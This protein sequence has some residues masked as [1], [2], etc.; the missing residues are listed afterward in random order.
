VK[1]GRR[2]IG[3]AAV[4]A[5][6]MALAGPASVDTADDA[7]NEETRL[8]NAGARDAIPCFDRAIRLNPR[9]ALAYN[10]RGIAWREK[11]DL[12]RAIADFDRATEL[13]PKNARA[14][15]DRGIAQLLLW[16]DTEA[17]KDFAKCFELDQGMRKVFELLIEKAKAKHAGKP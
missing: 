12:S 8:L 11:G 16:K 7:Y 15:G 17:Q 4:I 13:N 6:C 2:V 9:L 10:N 3:L 1:I 5:L 14:Y